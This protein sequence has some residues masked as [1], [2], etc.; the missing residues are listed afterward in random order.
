MSKA[1]NTKVRRPLGALHLSIN[2]IEAPAYSIGEKVTG[3][4]WYLGYLSL[5]TPVLLKLAG[6]PARIARYLAMASSSYRE[7]GAHPG[8]LMVLIYFFSQAF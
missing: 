3:S 7:I 8:V 6:T 1:H 5:S 2:K 4:S